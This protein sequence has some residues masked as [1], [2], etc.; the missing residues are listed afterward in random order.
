MCIYIK[1]KKKVIV[2][3]SHNSQ[4]DSLLRFEI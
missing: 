3:F 1:N 2:T 4:E